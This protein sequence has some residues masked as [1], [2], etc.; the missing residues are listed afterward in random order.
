MRPV[1]IRSWFVR[2]D[3]GTVRYGEMGEVAVI[4]YGFLLHP[5]FRPCLN[6]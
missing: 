3:C 2:L 1:A 4:V 5:Q 6:Q